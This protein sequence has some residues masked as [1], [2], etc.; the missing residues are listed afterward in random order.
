MKKLLII[1]WA[2]LTVVLIVLVIYFAQR[3][4]RWSDDIID[5]YANLGINFITIPNMEY[6]STNFPFDLPIDLLE[7]VGEP[8]GEG[9]FNYIDHPEVIHQ[10]SVLHDVQ[11]AFSMLLAYQFDFIGRA[12]IHI[13]HGIN[14]NMNI[15]VE[16]ITNSI[17]ITRDD[18]SDVAD[19]IFE[20]FVLQPG[21]RIIIYNMNNTSKV[22]TRHFQ[23]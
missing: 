6:T 20:S 12:G 18:L 3:E 7:V 1:L 22:Y 8:W 4:P 2:L 9:R 23:P 13:H 5:F 14:V 10:I 11:L 16:D 19:F 21:S 15:Y 17:E